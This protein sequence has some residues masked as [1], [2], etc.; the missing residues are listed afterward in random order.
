[1]PHYSLGS[2]ANIGSNRAYA[3]EVGTFVIMSTAPISEFNANYLCGD[4]KV[5]R[6][7]LGLGGGYSKI[8]DPE[9]REI[10]TKLD[11]DAE[12]ILYAEIDTNKCMTAKSALDNVGHYARQDVFKVTLN[13]EA[14]QAILPGSAQSHAR[15]RR[16]REAIFADGLSPME[17]RPVE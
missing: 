16:G 3:I 17:S 15:F 1:M 5:K 6:E 7:M 9:G 13:M 2:I 14:R 12:G 10:S 4:D 11:H 8:F